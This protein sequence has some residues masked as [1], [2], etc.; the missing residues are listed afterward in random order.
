MLQDGQETKSQSKVL[1]R[2]A[3]DKNVSSQNKTAVTHLSQ[4]KSNESNI[5]Y[6]SKSSENASTDTSS[7]CLVKRGLRI[8]NLNICHLIP[9]FDDINLLLKGRRTLDILGVCETFFNDQICD[10][11]LQIDGCCF[12][13]KD[14]EEKVRRW[15]FS[16]YI[17]FYQL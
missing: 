9:K 10:N 7:F 3:S 11:V 12:E 16:I 17:K 2:K 1:I 14:R 13:R 8:G 5:N 15:Y 4:N 6:T